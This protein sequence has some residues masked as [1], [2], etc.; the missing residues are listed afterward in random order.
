[1]KYMK[2]SNLDMFASAWAEIRSQYF[3]NS[4]EFYYT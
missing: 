4:K 2:Q 1:M 3:P